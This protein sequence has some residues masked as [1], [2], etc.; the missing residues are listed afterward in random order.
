MN[1]HQ[2]PEEVTRRLGSIE[3]YRKKQVTVE[4]ENKELVRN[5][6]Q[7]D[8]DAFLRAGGKV[9][10]VPTRPRAK[11]V[12]NDMEQISDVRKSQIIKEVAET[13]SISISWCK[14]EKKYVIFVNG[15][16]IGRHID[17]L[18]ACFIAKREID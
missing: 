6:L 5:L 18:Q 4:Q 2:L 10:V 8:V 17:R 1:A 12:K 13:E 3:F 14:F 9:E 11:M 16:F 15:Q 7:Q